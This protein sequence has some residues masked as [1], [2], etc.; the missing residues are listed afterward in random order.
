[1]LRHLKHNWSLTGILFKASAV[2]S[3]AA[4]GACTADSRSP[5]TRRCRVRPR[6]RLYRHTRRPLWREPGL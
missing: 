1:M 5:H 4:L 3:G 6:A 2:I